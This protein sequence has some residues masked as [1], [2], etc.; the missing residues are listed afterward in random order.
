MAALLPDYERPPIGEV[1]LAVQFEAMRGAQTAHLGE[2]LLS[3]KPDWVVL[4]ETAPLGPSVEP[5]DLAPMWL[6][7]A[8][9][10]QFLPAT[11]SRLRAASATG[12]RMVQL[13]NGW[14]VYNW[15]LTEPGQP[16]PRYSVLKPAFLKELAD[17]I[18]FAKRRSLGEFRPTLWEVGYV[19]FVP[20]GT[21][22]NAID[23]WPSIVP[24]LMRER[25]GLDAPLQTMNG[26][27]AFVVEPGKCRLQVMVEHSRL[28]IGDGTEAMLLKLIARGPVADQTVAGL[29]SGLD[30][31][32][33]HVVTSFD[34]LI[35]A[36]AA[37]HW[38]KRR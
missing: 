24:G 30:M 26:R 35:S 36:Q 15:R 10:L 37:A 25:S 20:K 28:E 13:E 38:G 27:W 34:R 32:H 1:V 3:R 11:A 23:E 22:W 21:L 9:A 18:D 2:F 33:A 19:N 8:A 14:L 16:Y 5:V 17:W 6:P 7:Q 29:T 4:P 12:D 31:G